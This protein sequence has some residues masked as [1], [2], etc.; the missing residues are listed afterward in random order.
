M[1]IN[2]IIGPELAEG[3]LSDIIHSC[4][5]SIFSFAQMVASMLERQTIPNNDFS[6]T[7]TEKAGNIRSH[8]S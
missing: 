2:N 8:K 3:K 5:S 6:I 4:G 1:H 7:K